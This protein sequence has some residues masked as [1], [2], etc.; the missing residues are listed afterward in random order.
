MEF[1][2]IFAIFLMVNRQFTKKGEKG[3]Q[4]DDF[5]SIQ[6]QKP[7]LFIGFVRLAHHGGCHRRFVF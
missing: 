4:Q 7:L 1:F 3:T 2:I 6:T 5:H